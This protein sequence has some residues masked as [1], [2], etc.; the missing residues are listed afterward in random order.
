MIKTI[1]ILVGCLSLTMASLAQAQ[2]IQ[3]GMSYSG[4]AH[5]E[6]PG[7]GATFIVPQG[8]F[9]QYDPREKLFNMNSPDGQQITV[10]FEGQ[11]YA[12]AIAKAKQPIT[13]SDGIV[14]RPD[15]NNIIPLQG[16]FHGKAFTYS[17]KALVFMNVGAVVLVIKMPSGKAISVSSGGLGQNYEAFG[18]TL[19]WV[20]PSLSFAGESTQPQRALSMQ[21]AGGDSSGQRQNL[22]HRA[23]RFV[24]GARMAGKA[25]KYTVGPP[26]W[27][28][29]SQQDPFKAHGNRKLPK[30]IDHKGTGLFWRK[31]SLEQYDRKETNFI[32]TISN[33]NLLNASKTK[34]LIFCYDNSKNTY[35]GTFITSVRNSMNTDWK[36]VDTGRYQIFQNQE[37]GFSSSV[38]GMIDTMFLDRRKGGGDIVMVEK[39][40]TGKRAYWSSKYA[41]NGEVF[42]AHGINTSCP[43]HQ[44]KAD[45]VQYSNCTKDQSE[46]VCSYKIWPERY[47]S[48][49]TYKSDKSNRSSS[50][51]SGSY[52]SNSQNG[53]ASMGNGCIAVSIPGGAGMMSCDPK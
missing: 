12:D 43:D 28:H 14:M 18:D 19:G 49:G 1:M 8:L 22:Y 5:L 23:G 11:N 31:F 52:Y 30:Y 27:V 50:S 10:G 47:Y 3:A 2:V 53:S 45:F 9:G 33:L 37:H 20:M 26:A 21:M 36:K 39:T 38:E 48:D 40:H 29:Y 35:R 15:L 7:S 46:A 44:P 17:G 42:T 4:G 41:F 25:T 51:S 13:T 6:L 32:A 16:R 34:R 24:A